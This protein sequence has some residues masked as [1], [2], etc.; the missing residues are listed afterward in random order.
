[1]TVE[2][3]KLIFRVLGPK[4]LKCT[5]LLNILEK[6]IEKYALNAEIV[7]DEKHSD[8]KVENFSDFPLMLINGRLLMKG[9]A[10]GEKE[11]IRTIN[12]MLPAEEIIEFIEPQ[13]EKKKFKVRWTMVVFVV[14][15]IIFAIT[16]IMWNP[17]HKTNI[18]MNMHDSIQQEYNYVENGK[19]YLLTFIEFG[20]EN[21]KACKDMKPIIEQIRSDFDGEINYFYVDVND[22]L[23]D[24]ICNYYKIG[25][26]PV[27]LL[28]DCE[29]EIFHKSFGLIMYDSLSSVINSKIE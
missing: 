10:P 29:A 26:S 17:A 18:P 12:R 11:L 7:H 24:S 19:D 28:L 13:T 6:V 27:H 5:Q 3:T 2:K 9:R 8:V 21:C 22:T 15:V 23:N 1:M 16:K 14:A 4:V 20:S 25:L